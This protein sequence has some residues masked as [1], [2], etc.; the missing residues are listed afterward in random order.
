MQNV[1]GTRQKQKKKRVRRNINKKTRERKEGSIKTQHPPPLPPIVFCLNIKTKM[2]LFRSQKNAL[3]GL[4]P[5]MTHINRPL[6]EMTTRLSRINRGNRDRN[7][8]DRI[9]ARNRFISLYHFYPLASIP[10]YLI[11]WG[12]LRFRSPNCS[13]H[14]PPTRILLTGMCTTV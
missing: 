5:L 6:K 14:A 12:P 13:H 11:I 3:S 2:V 7:G 8:V 9:F 10:E 4:A 1:K